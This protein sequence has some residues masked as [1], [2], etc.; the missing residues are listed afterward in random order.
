MP[1]QEPAAEAD[2][3]DD[4]PPTMRELLAACAAA[5]AVSTPPVSTSPVSTSP[6]AASAEDSACEGED[7]R[8]RD[9]A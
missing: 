2:R 6:S 4:R 9:A 3:R 5:N 1:S 7:E 8:R